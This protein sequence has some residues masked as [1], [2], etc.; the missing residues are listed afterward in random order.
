MREGL[1]RTDQPVIQYDSSEARSPMITTS[2]WHQCHGLLSQ[3]FFTIPM[4]AGVPRNLPDLNGL[5][6]L[7]AFVS[8]AVHEA[9]MHSPLYRHYNV[10]YV[11]SESRLCRNRPVKQPKPSRVNVSQY[12][13]GGTLLL[14][15]STWPSLPAYGTDAFQLSQRQCFCGWDGDGVN[16]FPPAVVC[17]TLPALCPSF[18]FGTPWTAS[19]PS[20]AAPGPARS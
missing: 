9:Y 12:R 8:A 1:Y 6:G 13:T 4:Q 11:P 16:C 18:P 2:I 5:D 17:Q 19:W 14:D 10:S 20:G 3:L 7:D 15:T